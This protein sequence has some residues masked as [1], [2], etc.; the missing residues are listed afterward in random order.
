MNY[1][2]TNDT[3]T[4]IRTVR[5]LLARFIALLANSGQEH[6]SSKLY[7]PE[8]Q[9]FD[10]YTP[11]LRDTTYGSEEYKKYLEGMGPALQHHYK[12]NRHHPEHFENGVTGMT[13]IDLIE[14]FVDWKAATLR[15]ADGNFLESIDHNKSRFD[16][17]PQLH[18]IMINTAKALKWDE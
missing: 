4:H 1:D 2:S 6:D 18:Q 5:E 9:I 13:L 15:H 11:K 12:N 14:M 17:S 7:P 3:I 8:K 16:I 10:E